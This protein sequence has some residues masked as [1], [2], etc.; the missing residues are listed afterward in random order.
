MSPVTELVVT[1]LARDLPSVF[2]N[3]TLLSERITHMGVHDVVLVVSSSTH[4]NFKVSVR[5]LSKWD[6]EQMKYTRY[7]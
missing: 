1:E 6:H 5:K 7:N 4:P 2:V 3:V